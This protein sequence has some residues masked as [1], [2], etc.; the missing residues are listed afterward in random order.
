MTVLFRRTF[1]RSDSQI[2]FYVDTPEFTQY[3]TDTYVNTGKCIIWRNTTESDTIK[4]TESTWISQE[5][6]DEAMLDE[7]ILL[8]S[9]LTLQHCQSNLIENYW[10]IE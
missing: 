6:L 3:M 9:S 10:S 4:T 5:E 2:P 7:Q 1:V 8:N